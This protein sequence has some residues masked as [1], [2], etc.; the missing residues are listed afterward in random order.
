MAIDNNSILDQIRLNGSDDY[1]QRIP[2][3]SQAGVTGVM[4]HLFDGQNIK[5]FN[6]FVGL[7]G[8]IGL[9]IVRDRVFS[10]PLSIFRKGRIPFGTSIQEIASGLIQAHGYDISADDL[11]KINLPNTK[12]AIHSVNDQRRYDYTINMSELRKAFL[13]ENGLSQYISSLQTSAI[14]SR[15]NDDFNITK[16][17]MAEYEA[18]GNG[19]FKVAVDVVNDETS[20]KKLLTELRTKV[21]EIK[22]LSSLYNRSGYPTFSEPRNLVFLTTPRVVANI[23]VNVLA[24]A[25]N[26]SYADITTRVVTIDQFP[27]VDGAGNEPVGLL[28]DEDAFMIYEYLLETR[29]FDNPET[30]NLNFYV[31]TWNLFSISPFLNAILFVT[32]DSTNIPV[33]QVDITG[34]EAEVLDVSGASVTSITKGERYKINVEA[35]GTVDP[36]NPN[37]SVKPDSATFTI[38]ADSIPIG[39]DPGIQITNGGKLYIRKD[40]PLV[41]GDTFTV[42]VKSTYTNPSGETA[43]GLSTVL[44]LTVA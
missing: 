28:I 21:G 20:A 9:T 6:E 2:E 15:Q 38:L 39:S 17:L 4:E 22:F 1:Q 40:S 7:L 16:Q 5:L 27:F 19:F 30:L 11:F 10:N 37:V 8:R 32:D 33:V 13:A 23:D 41:T 44:E 29:T 35:Q 26:V 18:Q 36:T 34:I 43:T 42:T 12:Q 25:F 3:A 24:A 14:N 31:H